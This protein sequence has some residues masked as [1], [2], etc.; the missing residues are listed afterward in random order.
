MENQDS[1]VLYR[2]KNG[3]ME[4]NVKLEKE[5][6]W[7]TQQQI[8][9]LFAAERSVITK[10]L[11]NIFYSNELKEKSNVQKMH[12]ALSDKPVKLY[13]L[14]VVLSVGYRVNSKQATQFRI[15]ATS[16]LRK[17]LTNGYVLNE[18]RLREQAKKFEELQKAIALMSRTKE[19]KE[20]NYREAIGLLDIIRDYS[21]ALDL[22]D[23]YDNGRLKVTGTTRKDKFRI[24]YENASQ[25]IWKMKTRLGG[26]DI[27]G[28]EKDQSFKSSVAAIYQTFD[29]RE[30]YPSVEEKAASLLYFIIKNH[31][32]VD[33][34]K[35]IAAAIF[36]WFL[37]GNELLYREDGS[38]RLADNALVALTLMIAES[39]PLERDVITALVVNLINKNN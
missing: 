26:T 4:I 38:K 1:I 16:I 10:H 15:W 3:K 30:L 31:S 27:F 14:D 19:A 32:F 28:A 5:T 20:L 6:V 24:T 23:D 17:Y 22:L 25:A 36:L 2:T 18:R 8:A 7:L 29:G 35:R 21:Y 33:G 37:E 13:N 11:Y 34:N 39:K 12:I 9:K